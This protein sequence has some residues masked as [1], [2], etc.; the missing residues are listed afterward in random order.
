MSLKDIASS[1]AQQLLCARTPTDVRMPSTCCA[2]VT[3]MMG[4]KF[5]TI[6]AGKYRNN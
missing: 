2:H 6:V 3:Q 1:V 4:G 5:T